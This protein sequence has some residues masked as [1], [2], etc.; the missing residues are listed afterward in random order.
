LVSAIMALP[1]LLPVT[2]KDSRYTRARLLPQPTCR[3]SCKTVGATGLRLVISGSDHQREAIQLYSETFRLARTSKRNDGLTTAIHR[4]GSPTIQPSLPAGYS[5]AYG[6]ADGFGGL[7]GPGSFGGLGAAEMAGL[8]SK[9]VGDELLRKEHADLHAEA[10]ELRQRVARLEAELAEQVAT[11]NSRNMI[12]EYGAMLAPFAPALA[13]MLGGSGTP[14]GGAVLGLGS[15]SAEASSGAMPQDGEGGESE[16]TRMVTGLVG[17]FMSSLSE[18]HQQ[19]LLAVMMRI[20][21]DNSL[22]PRIHRFLSTS[23]AQQQQQ[24]QQGN[25]AK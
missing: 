9:R 12:K 25:D 3:Q 16:Q 20:R 13:S 1:P 4:L 15:A 10:G 21:Q 17:E 11:N 19:Q 6:V 14:L 5:A 22:I 7:N 18:G 23:Q 8:V 2:V 24:Q